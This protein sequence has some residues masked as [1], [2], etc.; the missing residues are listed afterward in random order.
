MNTLEKMRSLNHTNLKKVSAPDQAKKDEETLKVLGDIQNTLKSTSYPNNQEKENIPS[1]NNLKKNS[2]ID[3]QGMTQVSSQSPHQEINQ[4][5]EQSSPTEKKTFIEE[6]ESKEILNKGNHTNPTL[7]INENAQHN[8]STIQNKEKQN[9]DFPEKFNEMISTFKNQF[10][11]E[12]VQFKSNLNQEYKSKLAEEQDTYSYSLKNK[13]DE[14]EK[15]REEFTKLSQQKNKEDIYFEKLSLY[16]KK[17]KN[18][19]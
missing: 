18:L 14:L 10:Y 5:L 16:T 1:C 11:Q 15:L 19:S 17:M 2:Q 9:E 12:Y 4:T 3:K 6:K 13:E 8:S 7:L